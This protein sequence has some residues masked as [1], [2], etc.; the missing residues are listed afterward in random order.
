[1]LDTKAP[2]TSG[3]SVKVDNAPGGTP[4]GS[5]VVIGHL[6]SLG[7]LV[8]MSRSEKKYK[9]YNDG[10]F[11]EIVSTGSLEKGP[12]TCS[13]LYDPEGNHGAN[14]MEAAIKNDSE[15][16]IIIVLNNKKTDAGNGTTY[17]QVIKVTKFKVDGEL[18]GKTKAD[19]EGVRI[20]EPEKVPAA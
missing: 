11:N 20:G 5:P 15:V 16:Q 4:A 9:P 7:S 2:D 12:F 10:D 3:I 1:M 14:L 13:V 8:D 19:I 17:K 6:E 18:E